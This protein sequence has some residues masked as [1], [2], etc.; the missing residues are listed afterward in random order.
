MKYLLLLLFLIS[1]AK[2][3]DFRKSNWNDTKKQVLLSEKGKP[4]YKDDT[5]IAYKDRLQ[6]LDVMVIFIFINNKL[7]IGSYTITSA[8][9]NR[10]LYLDDYARLKSAIT[11]KYGEPIRDYDIWNNHLFEDDQDKWGT[12]LSLGHMYYITDWESPFISLFMQG[13]NGEVT[14][15]VTYS[16]KPLTEVLPKEEDKL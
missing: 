13:D 3:E 7:Q 14:L 4:V 11:K 16:S 9:R 5:R 8:H 2:A 12:A 6:G 15:S 1:T 10:N